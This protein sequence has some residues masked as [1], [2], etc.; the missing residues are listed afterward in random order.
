MPKVHV[1]KIIFCFHTNR[2]KK[3]FPDWKMTKFCPYFSRL[4]RYTVEF[5]Y[6]DFGYKNR[7]P[8]M[9]RFLRSRQNP[10]LFRANFFGLPRIFRS[11][12]KTDACSLHSFKFKLGY[13]TAA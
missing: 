2:R 9:T 12:L 4:R 1:W 13:E 3:M 5:A 10:Y 6:H 7:T 8:I 11:C